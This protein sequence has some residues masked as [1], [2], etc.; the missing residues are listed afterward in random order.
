[1]QQQ[2]YGA[3]DDMEGIVLVTEEAIGTHHRLLGRRQVPGAVLYLVEI[4]HLEAL[5]CLPDV[6]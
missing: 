2:Q 4:R 6:Q 1:M 3:D 5:L